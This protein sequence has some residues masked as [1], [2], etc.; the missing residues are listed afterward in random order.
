VKFGAWSGGV[1]LKSRLKVM[2]SDEGVERYGRERRRPMRITTRSSAGRG[3]AASRGDGLLRLGAWNGRPEAWLAD[4]LSAG[5]NCYPGIWTPHDV[6]DQTVLLITLRVDCV[7]QNHKSPGIVSLF[8]ASVTMRMNFGRIPRYK[9][10]NVDKAQACRP[11]RRIK[12][13]TLETSFLGSAADSRN[14]GAQAA[15]LHPSK[16]KAVRIL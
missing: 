5:P 3:I 1:D 9:Y 13:I 10:P 2:C 11:N 6:H 14:R 4:R 7:A 16:A 12:M 8:T 15:E